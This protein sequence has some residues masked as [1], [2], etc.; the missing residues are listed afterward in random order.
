MSNKFK[1]DYWCSFDN[2]NENDPSFKQEA[3]FQK[4]YALVVDNIVVVGSLFKGGD[5][6]KAGSSHTKITPTHFFDSV[7]LTKDGGAPCEC[8]EVLQKDFDSRYNKEVQ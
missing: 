4:S 7:R 2:L 6:I 1:R 3:K 8:L 5:W